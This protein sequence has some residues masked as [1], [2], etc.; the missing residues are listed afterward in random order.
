MSKHIKVGEIDIPTNYWSMSEEER[1]ELS[2]TLMEDM[3][4]ILD[5]TLNPEFDRID[6]LDLLLISSIISNEEKEEYEICDVMSSIRKILN[7]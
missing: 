2:L 1:L 5:K 6:I 3:L 4:I 7:D